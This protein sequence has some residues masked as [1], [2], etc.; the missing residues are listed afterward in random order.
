MRQSDLERLGAERILILSARSCPMQKAQYSGYSRT[1][2]CSLCTLLAGGIFSLMVYAA[3]PSNSVQVSPGQDVSAAVQRAPAGTTFVFAPGLYRGVSIAPKD[4]D[5]F[6]GQD[7]VVLNGSVRLQMRQDGNLWSAGQPVAKSDPKYC[8]QDHPRCFILS[9]LFIDD[10]LQEPVASMDELT[11]G[12]WYYDLDSQKV[13]VSSDPTGHK[14]E[15]SL[16]AGAFV[17][18]AT[19]VEISHLIVEKYASPP[20][21]G[22]IGSGG[23]RAVPAGWTVSHVEVRWNHG[24][25]IRVGENGRIDSC[26]VHDNGQ[27]GL[28]GSGA[29]ITVSNNIIDR[30]NYAGYRVDW[31]AGATKFA[32]TDHLV[33]KSNDVEKN[34]GNGIWTDI[35]NIH[36]LI[37]GNKIF[38]NVNEGIRHEIGYDAI[39]RNNLLRG[40]EAGIVIALSANV[41]V[42]GNVIEVPENGDFGIRLDAGHRNSESNGEYRLQNV[43]VHDNIISYLGAKG[44]GGLIG[45]ASTASAI[46]I[47][48]NE[49]H[50]ANGT[51]KDRWRWNNHSQG[52]EEMHQLGMEVHAKVLGPLSQ[53]PDPT[54]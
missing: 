16:T 43:S 50:L 34:Q 53:L 5:R 7:N 3:D 2:I 52:L 32:N 19:G 49:Y 20:Q 23:T 6:I 12:R 40:N 21:R 9:D 41:E 39:I 54:H 4:G 45:D 15:L 37:E 33:V 47:D 26:N 36:V 1:K 25:G 30:N 51:Q 22:A 35:D 11:A 48:R 29:N 28:G 18:K 31:E 8:R 10:Q 24:Q 44:H 17:G 46:S 27:L 13:Y 38:D 14:V 42:Y